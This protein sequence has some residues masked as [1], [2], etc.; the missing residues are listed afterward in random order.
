VLIYKD[1]MIASYRFQR[2]VFV[3]NANIDL[4]K[5]EFD[6]LHFLMLNRG[7]VLS[8]RQIFK[9]VWGKQLRGFIAGRAVERQS[10]YPAPHVCI[11]AG[12]VVIGD[13]TQFI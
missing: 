13:C 1:L 7:K 6:I 2:G 11:S 12:N 5:Q 10:V 8:Y 4:S 9:R 3:G